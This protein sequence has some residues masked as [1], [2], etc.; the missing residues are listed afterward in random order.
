VIPAR[1]RSQVQRT[2]HSCPKTFS[3]GVT[4]PS[5][6]SGSNQRTMSPAAGDVDY[7]EQQNEINRLREAALTEIWNSMSLEGVPRLC[8]LSQDPETIGWHLVD[9]LDG[10]EVSGFARRVLGRRGRGRLCFHLGLPG[11]PAY[12]Y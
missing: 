3:I 1:R 8:N 2:N 12:S 4:G 11:G 6:D 9:V 10:A 5:S 7:A